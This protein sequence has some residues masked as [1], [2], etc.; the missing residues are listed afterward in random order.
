LEGEKLLHQASPIKKKKGLPEGQKRNTRG[1]RGGSSGLRSHDRKKTA[2]ILIPEERGRQDRKGKNGGK[3]ETEKRGE[4][5]KN[6]KDPP[7]QGNRH[8]SNPTKER[9]DADFKVQ[10]SKKRICQ[11]RK[12]PACLLK[13]FSVGKK[14]KGDFAW[15]R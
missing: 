14:G 1:E 5:H 8:S 2:L 12:G 9:R 7:Q 13:I 3:R 15:A 10:L 4:L 11:K 6:R